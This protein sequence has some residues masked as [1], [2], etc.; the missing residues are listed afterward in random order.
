[1]CVCLLV[2]YTLICVCVMYVNLCVCDVCLC[3]MYVCVCAPF[4]T[5]SNHSL[6]FTHKYKVRQVLVWEPTELGEGRDRHH[7]AS[8]SGVRNRGVPLYTKTYV[9]T[10]FVIYVIVVSH[11]GSVHGKC[12]AMYQ[13]NSPRVQP[14]VNW[15][16]TSQYISHVQS[17]SGI[18]VYMYVRT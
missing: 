18:Q 14:E 16:H 11:F 10:V 13:I 5:L 2:W 4:A 17:Q 9:R 12:T 6:G 7:P 8:K 1:M 15:F 3:V